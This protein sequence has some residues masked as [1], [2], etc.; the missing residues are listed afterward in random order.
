MDFIQRTNFPEVE[1]KI[2][3]PENNVPKT[4][5]RDTSPDLRYKHVIFPDSDAEPKVDQMSAAET[6]DYTSGIYILGN[7]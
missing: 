2:K 7:G 1:T 6:I 4:T 5:Q 3:V